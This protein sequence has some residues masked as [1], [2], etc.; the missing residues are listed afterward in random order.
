MQENGQNIDPD[1]GLPFCTF[2]PDRV[3]HFYCTSHKVVILKF[4]LLVVEF[5]YKLVIINQ[6]VQ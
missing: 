3:E 4:R 2:H 5:V 1:S 6:I